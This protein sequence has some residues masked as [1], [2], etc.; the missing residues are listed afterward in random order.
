[1]LKELSG[2]WRTASLPPNKPRLIR[3]KSDLD[4]TV[5]HSTS[6]TVPIPGCGAV[7][8]DRSWPARCCDIAETRRRALNLGPAK[9][10][11]V[12][13][14]FPLASPHCFRSSGGT[15]CTS[16]G[17]GEELASRSTRPLF[18]E[19]NRRTV[20]VSAGCGGKGRRAGRSAEQCGRHL[21][22]GLASEIGYLWPWRA[23]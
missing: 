14:K 5:V 16:S 15:R 4:A 11:P 7:G 21:Q 23:V 9:S 17:R 1:V 13:T 22:A 2:S 3:E 20:F 8:S 10:M 19:G 18:P 12:R 6:I